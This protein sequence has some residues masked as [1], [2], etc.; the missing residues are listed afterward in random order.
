MRFE[1]QQADLGKIP[2]CF[3][4]HGLLAEFFAGLFAPMRLS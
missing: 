3:S 4:E 1:P 2:E